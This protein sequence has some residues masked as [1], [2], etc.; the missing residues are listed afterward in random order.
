MSKHIRF[1]KAIIGIIAVLLITSFACAEDSIDKS[2]GQCSYHGGLDKTTG[3]CKDGTDPG[4][5]K[6]KPTGLSETQ[7][8]ILKKYSAINDKLVD[9]KDGLMDS[10]E[11]C[12][13]DA[14]NKKIDKKIV[15]ADKKIE[16]NCIHILK[17]DPAFMC[18]MSGN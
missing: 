8:K 1:I 17:Y 5:A 3:K 6:E 9:E 15:A 7:K 16:A 2:T 10:K 18:G 14:C 11:G 12:E 13:T 4:A